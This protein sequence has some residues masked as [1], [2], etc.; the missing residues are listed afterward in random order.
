MIRAKDILSLLENWL[1]YGQSTTRLSNKPEDKVYDIFE[2]PT[3]S[4]YRDLGKTIRFTADVSSKIVYAWQYDKA[5]HADTSRAVGIAHK[6]NDP[7]L[8]LGAAEWGGGTWKFMDS[9]FLRSFGGRLTADD[10]KY[11]QVLTSRNWTWVDRYI[12]VT[13]YLDSLKKRLGL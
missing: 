7:D 2:N 1:K 11:L 13:P 10:R 3:Q 8:L 5:F 12:L 6:Y 4:D 9:D